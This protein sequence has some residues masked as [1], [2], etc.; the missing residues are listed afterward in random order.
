M[1]RLIC[2]LALITLFVVLYACTYHL[3]LENIDVSC[4]CVLTNKTTKEHVVL[5]QFYTALPY[6]ELQA[7]VG[8]EIN[9]TLEISVDG[10]IS[11]S[12]ISCTF[13]DTEYRLNSPYKWEMDYVVP[14]LNK[15]KYPVSISGDFEVSDPNF[16][17]SGYTNQIQS[18]GIGLTM[19]VVIE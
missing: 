5:E 18:C 7:S 12:G 15:G 8:D 16:G 1:R 14:N 11:S 17:L 4:L 9:L 13:L 19:L 6:P 2:R 3:S 10:K